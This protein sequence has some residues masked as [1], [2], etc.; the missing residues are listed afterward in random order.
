MLPNLRGQRQSEEHAEN[1]A[2]VTAPVAEL[3]TIIDKGTSRERPSVYIDRDL[4][5][6]VALALREDLLR[7]FPATHEWRKRLAVLPSAEAREAVKVKQKQGKEQC[8][9][10]KRTEDT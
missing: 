9:P 5:R 10:V 3:Y 2:P 7:H 8:R 6:E 1:T 4:P